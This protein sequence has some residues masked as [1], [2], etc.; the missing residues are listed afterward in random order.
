MLE[1]ENTREARKKLQEYKQKLGELI[2][3]SRYYKITKVPTTFALN[4]IC[5]RPSILLE[6][7]L[8]VKQNYYTL[9]HRLPGIMCTNNIQDEEV[10][11]GVE[12]GW[13]NDI[14][15]QRSTH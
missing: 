3:E 9:V 11:G 5:P 4:F 2:R 13:A 14:F 8:V 1:H 6:G 7:S 10:T 15:D 12:R